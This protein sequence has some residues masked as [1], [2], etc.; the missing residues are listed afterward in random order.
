MDN[1]QT[2]VNAGQ[3]EPDDMLPPVQQPQIT[4]GSQQQLPEPPVPQQ[5]VPDSRALVA[6]PEAAES[7]LIEKE[8]VVKAKQIVDRT[9]ED[10]HLQQQELTRIKA[11]YLKKRYNRDLGSK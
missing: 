11:E 8:W 9:A 7:D 6:T 3:N 4:N 5:T 10:P 1:Q 2:P